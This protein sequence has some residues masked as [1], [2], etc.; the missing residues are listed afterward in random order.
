M[1]SGS[2][3]AVG[4]GLKS[5]TSKVET[6]QTFELFDKL[7]T[8]VDTPG[9]DDTTVSDTDI[10]KMI[11]VYLSTTYVGLIHLSVAFTDTTADT[12]AGAS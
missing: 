11:A 8:L 1:I 3:L 4:A 6:A 9:F 7:V 12:R 2:H 10:L 5:C